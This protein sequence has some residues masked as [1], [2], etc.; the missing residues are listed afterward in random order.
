MRKC[1]I[2]LKEKESKYFNIWNNN[3][4][5]ECVNKYVREYNCT[6]DW[7]ITKMYSAQRRRSEERWHSLP[8]YTNK[9]INHWVRS[10]SNFL[11]LYNNRKISWYNRSLIPSIDR[12]DDYKWYSFDNIRLTIWRENNIKWSKDRKNWINNK[13]NRCVIW[14]NIT[15]W[16]IIEFYSMS[17]ASRVTWAG[18]WHICSCCKWNIKSAW[19]YIWK[20]K[21]I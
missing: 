12:L 17:E 7:L 21:L 18:I 4:C 16:E 10:Q 1:N 5:K 9:Q 3:K 11:E 2:C 15:T 20:Y 6:I 8:S 14:I 19:G 13:M